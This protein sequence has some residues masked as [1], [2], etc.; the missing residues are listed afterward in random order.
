MIAGG[1]GEVRA[2]PGVE[3]T[4]PPVTGEGLAWGA[5]AVVVGVVLG[6]LGRHLVRAVMLARGRGESSAEVFGRLTSW[7]WGVVGIAAALTIVFP[8]VKPVDVLG[9]V[10]VIS[11][12]AGIAFQTVLGNMFAGIVILARDRFRTG[13]Q[14][15][16][17]DYRG[18][19]TSIQLSSTSLRTFDGRLVLI[20]NSVMHSNIVTVQTGFAAVR[21]TVGLDLDD[22]A[23]LDL[24]CRVAIETMRDLPEVIDNPPPEAQLAQIGT[25]TVHLELRFWSG[26]RQLETREARHAVI[27]AVLAAFARH[28]IPTG[29]DVAVIEAGPGLAGILRSQPDPCREPRGG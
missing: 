7:L 13:D 10:G 2:V 27:R 17:A 5:G 14:I 28:R 18:T 6:W 24:A 29:S 4:L 1:G 21:T 16:V 23:D 8:S 25:A 3:W 11:I 20:P 22:Q 12:A 19:V 9:G 26:A 15:A